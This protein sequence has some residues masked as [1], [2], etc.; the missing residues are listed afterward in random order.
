M[1]KQKEQSKEQIQTD[2]LKAN[3]ELLY[4]LHFYAYSNNKTEAYTF[5]NSNIVTNNVN[6]VKAQASQ[7]SNSVKVTQLEP[8]FFIKFEQSINKYFQAK[9]HTL[10]DSNELEQIRSKANLYK[11]DEIEEKKEDDI[12][13]TPISFSENF[14]DFD[15]LDL[16]NK[17]ELL[18]ELQRRYKLRTT[19]EKTRNEI[20][21]MIIDVQNMKKQEI[22]E[23]EDTIHYYVPLPLCDFCPHQKQIVKDNILKPYSE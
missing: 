11:E 13:V 23:D 6:S 10:I 7:Y 21:K 19:D 18:K 8:Q 20:T 12:E 9:G 2:F 5:A 16:S 17:D 15:D 1:A 4:L 22:Q 3:K 14:N